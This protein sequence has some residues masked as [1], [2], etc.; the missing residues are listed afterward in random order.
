MNNKKGMSLIVLVITILVMIILA[1]VVIVSLQQSNP[2]DQAKTAKNVTQIADVRAAI[3]QYAATQSALTDN[4]TPT[5]SAIYSNEAHPEYSTLND[6]K[7][8]AK[9]G[10]TDK[11]QKI[12]GVTTVTDVKGD[13]YVTT[14]GNSVFILDENQDDMAKLLLNEKELTTKVYEKNGIVYNKK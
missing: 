13:F 5:L 9:V 2:I 8:Y 12:L 3:N 7:T 11:I 10:E 4:G 1:G 6:Y 14:N